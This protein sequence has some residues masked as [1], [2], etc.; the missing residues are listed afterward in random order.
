MN[1]SD[2]N[3][4]ALKPH[5][6]I[7]EHDDGQDDPWI[8]PTVFEP[9]QLRSCDVAGDHG[10]ISPP[11]RSESSISEGVDFKRVTAVPSDKELHGVG[12]SHQR[13]SQQDDLAHI[14]DVLV[15]NQIVQIVD[16][17]KRNEKSENHGKAAEDRACDKVRRE[18]GGVPP[19]HN[20]GGEIERND[21][22]NGKN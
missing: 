20:G 3:H 17:T 1:R 6:R 21:A 16:F 18:D 15:G 22:V 5:A 14:V 4:K 11:V 8:L 2:D 19:G 13:P 12:V 9:K 10:P 7:G